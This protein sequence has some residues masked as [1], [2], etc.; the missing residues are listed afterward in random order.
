[1]MESWDEDPEARLTA[2]N[3]ASRLNMLNFKPEMVNINIDLVEDRA[4]D[5]SINH[6][7]ILVSMSET[8]QNT[9]N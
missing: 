2:A 7:E 6:S 8:S 5:F 3:I 1:M 9:D 4:G